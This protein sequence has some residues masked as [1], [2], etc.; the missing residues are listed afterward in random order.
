[1]IAKEN[2][3]TRPARDPIPAGMHQARCYA[4][5]DLGTHYDE[6][7]LKEKREL[8]IMWEVP[9]ERID[10]E[11]EGKTLDLPRA[12][13]K[14]YTLSLHEKARLR[15]DLESWRGRPFNTDELGGFD[16]KAIIG[17]P[18]LLN[19]THSKRDDKTYANVGA[20]TPLM[21]GMNAPEQENPSASFS[22]DDGSNV[23]PE[24]MPEWVCDIAAKSKEWEAIEEKKKAPAAQ[25]A[26]PKEDAKDDSLPF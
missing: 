10:I 2:Q 26:A 15:H 6:K 14:K 11:R 9:G 22:F 23:F 25:P 12:I 8:I 24:A 13:S 19:I 17:K 5:F 3:K 20:I 21:K 4:L 1:M 16:M 18:C 7:F